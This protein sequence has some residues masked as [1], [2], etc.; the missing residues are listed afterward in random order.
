[1]G[2]ANLSDLESEP[3]DLIIDCMRA[4]GA[5]TFGIPFDPDLE[6]GNHKML[7]FIAYG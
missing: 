2:R 3:S 4:Y 1:M 6:G 5:T 7:A